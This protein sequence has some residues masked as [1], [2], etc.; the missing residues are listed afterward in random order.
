MLATRHLAIGKSII[1]DARQLTAPMGEV[2]D[3]LAYQLEELKKYK[4]KYGELDDNRI[5]EVQ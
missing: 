3:D 4:E 2:L 1:Y 5:T